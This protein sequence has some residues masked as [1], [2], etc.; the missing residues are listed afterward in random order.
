MS[1]PFKITVPG[2]ASI[3]VFAESLSLA[4]KHARS[5]ASGEVKS[6]CRPITE[7]EYKTV[8]FKAE[9]FTRVPGGKE[10]AALTPYAL[11]LNDKTIYKLASSAS[12]AEKYLVG[13]IARVTGATV[14]PVPAEEY[15]SIDWSKVETLAKDEPAAKEDGKDA[16]KGD[17]DKQTDLTDIPGM[18]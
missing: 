4:E 16:A 11:T 17:A 8:D 13:E 7:A 18:D 6:E 3:V 1:R 9:T 12:N 5:L 10:D 2:M 14:E 15:P